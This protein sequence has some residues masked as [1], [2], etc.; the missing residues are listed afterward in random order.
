MRRDLS[1]VGGCRASQLDK[2]AHAACLSALRRLPGARDDVAFGGLGVGKLHGTSVDRGGDVGL[3]GQRF[4]LADDDVACFGQ[5][6]EH[7]FRVYHLDAAAV[8]SLACE[9][10][11]LRVVVDSFQ[12]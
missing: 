1:H 9:V 8:K 2:L 10:V 4:V 11:I 3:G 12:S 6:A 7:H 5:S